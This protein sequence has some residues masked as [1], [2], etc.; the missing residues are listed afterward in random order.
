MLVWD[1]VCYYMRVVQYVPHMVVHKMGVAEFG[2]RTSSHQNLEDGN[3]RLDRLT[4]KLMS[5]P[6]TPANI[7]TIPPASPRCT[8]V[9]GR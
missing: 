9:A 7:R 1:S 3:V 5:F 4:S 6:C 8:T 2:R